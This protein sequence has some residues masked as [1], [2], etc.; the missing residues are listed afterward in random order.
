VFDDPRGP[1]DSPVRVVPSPSSR[2]PDAPVAPSP[3]GALPAPALL[4]CTTS[5]SLETLRQTS[6][7][8]FDGTVTKIG[9]ARDEDSDD[10]AYVAVSFTVNQWFAGGDTD[11]VTVDMIPPEVDAFESTPPAYR[12]G[13]RLLVSGQLRSLT[14]ADRGLVAEACSGFTRYYDADTA[15]AWRGAY[16]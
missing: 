11:T 5:Y 8:A 14:D 2:T 15:T 9:P 6:S 3:S 13:T 7:F 10:G 12:T 1:T 4:R 16:R